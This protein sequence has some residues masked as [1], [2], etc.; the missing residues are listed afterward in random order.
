MKPKTPNFFRGNSN[1]ETANRLTADVDIVAFGIATD[2]EPNERREFLIEKGIEV[3][4]VEC[5]T[6]K[7]LLD[8]CF[9]VKDDEG[10]CQGI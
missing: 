4:K 6:R 5:L 7:E 1:P 8:A 10:Y 2:A 9:E 3:T